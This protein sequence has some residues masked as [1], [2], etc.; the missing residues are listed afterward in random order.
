MILTEMFNF[1]KKETSMETVM[2]DF[3]S[4]VLENYNF[5]NRQSKKI[6]AFFSIIR[7][8]VSYLGKN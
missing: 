8:H 3:K 2:E 5:E 7:Y 4:I 1:V 6:L